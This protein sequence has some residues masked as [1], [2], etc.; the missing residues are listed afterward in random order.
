MKFNKHNKFLILLVLLSIMTLNLA[1]RLNLEQTG[2]EQQDIAMNIL[3]NETQFV[4]SRDITIKLVQNV[5]KV[6]EINKYVG[7]WNLGLKTIH[8]NSTHDFLDHIPNFGKLIDDNTVHVDF[9][10]IM[11]CNFETIEQSNSIKTTFK[12]MSKESTS[13]HVYTIELIFQSKDNKIEAIIKYFNDISSICQSTQET[14]DILKSELT[15][16][17]KENLSLKKRKNDPIKLKVAKKTSNSSKT[18]ESLISPPSDLAMPGNPDLNLTDIYVHD[19]V[20]PDV[21]NK[22]KKYK[23]VMKSEKNKVKDL[24]A[25][26][27][28]LL[29]RANELMDRM[30]K[31]SRHLSIIVPKNEEGLS[32]KESANRTIVESN[33]TIT[34]YKELNQVLNTSLT[35][36]KSSKVEQDQ[37]VQNLTLEFNNIKADVNKHNE[38]QMNVRKS[39]AEVEAKANVD[40]ENLSN[41]EKKKTKLLM[42]IKDLTSQIKQD[43]DDIQTNQKNLDL[44]QT[45]FNNLEE[46]EK[47]AKKNEEELSVKLKDLMKKEND[48]KR[49]ID[50]K[51]LSSLESQKQK[52]ITDLGKLEEKLKKKFN[53]IHDI[54][55][56][57]YGE[58]IN[59][60]YVEITHK[61]NH[62]PET[63]K[64]IIK[65]IPEFVW[66]QPK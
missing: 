64:K 36:L 25:Q 53:E 40:T 14:A 65:T 4:T 43:S 58:I 24:K 22:I 66:S 31:D 1:A 6:K 48:I 45:N 11:G 7:Y 37:I 15:Q 41:I 17:V 47:K 27:P 3:N 5:Q 16:I 51:V 13:Q 42:K 39:I 18:N 63:Y 44:I 33:L 12:M 59:K 57:T 34:K 21:I 60:A 50:P 32:H 8:A 10:Y 23:H 19:I 2:V 20:D 30:D 62:D 54:I 26:R 38:N 35:T 61:D 9:R 28:I 29:N 52:T 46:E 49:Q 56:P 55:D